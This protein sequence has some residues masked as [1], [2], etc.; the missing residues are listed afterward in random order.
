MRLLCANLSG[1]ATVPRRKVFR[2]VSLTVALATLTAC[3][4]GNTP[5]TPTAIVAPTPSV[6]VSTTTAPRQT[7]APTGLTVVATAPAGP[8]TATASV[9]AT[10]VPTGGSTGVPTAAASATSLPLLTFTSEEYPYSIG[11]PRGWKAQGPGSTGGGDVRGDFFFPTAQRE[12][13]VSVNILSEEVSADAVPGT[14]QYVELTSAQI[15]R[16]TRTP[17]R[18]GGTM[19]VGGEEAVLINWSDRSRELQTTEIAQAIWVANGRGWV[20]TLSAPEG[21]RDRYLPVLEA[22]LRSFRAR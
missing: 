18:R 6:A 3:S 19:G 22:M 8:L 21:Q 2:C 13:D 9:P 17:P 4:L 16:I 15:E 12:T 14:E 7:V 11:Y 1:N 5:A 20:V 10:P